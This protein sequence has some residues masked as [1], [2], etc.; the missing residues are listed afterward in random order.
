[1][2]RQVVT[3]ETQVQKEECR[4]DS[5]GTRQEQ[6][7]NLTVLPQTLYQRDISDSAVLTTYHSLHMQHLKK[8]S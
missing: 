1:M 6:Q 4:L 3:W 7:A 8:N 5:S 2:K